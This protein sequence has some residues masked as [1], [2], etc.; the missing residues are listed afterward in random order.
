[1]SVL[2]CLSFIF[3]ANVILAAHARPGNLFLSD[4][5]E[6]IQHG[7][8]VDDFWSLNEL[9]SV[10]PNVDPSPL[11]QDTRA[12]TDN[13]NLFTNFS[14]D[15]FATDP[16]DSIIISSACNTEGSLTDDLLQARDEG[17]CST[18]EQPKQQD[19][20]LPNL[21]DDNF[22]PQGLGTSSTE[23]TEQSSQG[24]I[25]KQP[26]DP[27]WGAYGLG[28][29]E[30]LRLEEN[31]ELCP[32]DIFRASITP[33]CN[34]PSTGRIEYQF[35]KLYATMF[36]IIPRVY[37]FCLFLSRFHASFHPFLRC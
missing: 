6:S 3:V 18:M 19:I 22:L 33:V 7:P 14:S 37:F 30:A 16:S 8:L 31:P 25:D 17:S 24:T 2:P 28:I 26:G 12:E 13:V 9:A 11:A 15:I 20:N 21:L 27:G 23:Q 36:N 35:A 4:S 29:P 5:P 1:M 32:P 34:N 10:V